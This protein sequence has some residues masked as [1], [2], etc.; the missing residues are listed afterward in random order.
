MA[1]STR[2]RVD[3]LENA[4]KELAYAGR[5][6][7]MS[8][9]RLSAEMRDFKEEMSAFKDEMATFKNE[10]SA[11]KNEM[12]TFKN[13]MSAFKN[14]NSREARR[15]HEQWGALANKMG[16]FVEDMVLPN[17][18]HILERYFGVAEVDDMLVRRRKPHPLDPSRRKEFDLIAWTQE[19][20]FWN[21][22]KSSPTVAHLE[23]FVED[24]ESIF[25]YFPELSG[26][27]LIKIASALSMPAEV[28][29]Y[30]S[31]HHCYA[32]VL[33][34]ETMDLVNFADIAAR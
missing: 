33:G 27:R 10:V 16:T 3:T 29:G 30:L 19:L 12:T 25:E 32:M 26:R 6:T 22:T 9:D 15:M 34:D 1:M 20:L 28:V 21:E 13:E 23:A 18:P 5:R 31:A 4:L 11:F 17:F 2:E 14:E 24:Y 8:L 7:E